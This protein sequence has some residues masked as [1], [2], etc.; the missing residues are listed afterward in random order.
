[1][2]VERSLT[3]ESVERSRT[4]DKDTMGRQGASQ[5]AQ[6]TA[7]LR[8]LD[9]SSLSSRCRSFGMQNSSRRRVSTCSF[10][11]AEAHREP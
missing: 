2:S 1:M 11:C 3:I 9:A 4:G 6:Q 7:Y 8:F 10:S 5:R